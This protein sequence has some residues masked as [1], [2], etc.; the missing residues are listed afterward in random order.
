MKKQQAP[1][2]DPHLGGHNFVSHIDEALLLYFKNNLNCNSMID[3]GCGLGGMVYKAKELG[4]YSKG[5][6]GDYR[7][8][9]TDPELFI[10]HDFT[11][12]TC[13]ING[14]FDLGYSCEFV[15][16]VEE[17]YVDNFLD[18]FKKC[19]YITMTFA[20]PGTKG[21][22]HVNCQTSNYW[23]DKL[24]EVN[25]LYDEKLTNIIRSTSS[26]ERNFIRSTGLCFR[27][28]N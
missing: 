2:H 1:K 25:L 19:K 23:I 27:N 26:M 11:K 5:I 7:L 8:E 10:L 24:K 18:I 4:Y 21:H 12:G 15:E 16:H 3:I 22:H 6:D 17:A 14:T 20:P 13:N 28:E 9:R